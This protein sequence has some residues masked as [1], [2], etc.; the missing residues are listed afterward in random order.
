[1]S[2]P[3]FTKRHRKS[4]S[5]L[6]RWAVSYL[7]ILLI[8]NLIFMYS[9]RV[10]VS[11]MQN[12]IHSANEL[13]LS[14][15]QSNIDKLLSSA[16]EAYAYVYST[17]QFS[18]VKLYTQ[19]ND[20]F[21]YDVTKLIKSLGA[22][23]S[24]NNN[25]IAMLIYMKDFNYI[26]S[27][28]TANSSLAL[29]GSQKI[30]GM[31]DSYDDWLSALQSNYSNSFFLSS[32]LQIGN[33]EPCIIYANTLNLSTENINIFISIPLSRAEEYTRSLT[34]RTL[35]IND[36]D[37]NCI[38]SFGSD[39][40]PNYLDLSIPSGNRVAD[41]NGDY[42]I[43][44]YSKSTQTDWY[45]SIITPETSFFKTSQSLNLLFIGS[46]V[47]SLLLGATLV[48]LLL[49]RNYKPVG[50]IL[51][52]IDPSDSAGDE[53]DLIKSSYKQLANE[54]RTMQST[55][56]KQAEQLKERYILSRLKG[57]KSHLNNIDAN[58]YYQIDIQ[59]K[60]F[61]LVAFSVGPLSA[62][63]SANY[64]DEL[65][66]YDINLFAID[67]A[68]TEIMS[69]YSFYKMED[70]Q[71]LLYLLHLD[72]AQIKLWNSHAQLLITEICDLFLQKLSVPL[73]AVISETIENFNHISFLYSDVMA[74]MEYKSII[75]E[76]GVIN[77]ADL[78]DT[79]MLMDKN[80]MRTQCLSDAV[81]EGNFDKAKEMITNVFEE[82]KMNMALPFSVF[83]IVVTNYL[84]TILNSFY[85]SAPDISQHNKLLISKLEP[86]IASSETDTLYQNTCEFL[87][88]ICG[89]IAN[90]NEGK[91]NK[92]V[93]KMKDY[94]L[95]SYQDSNLNISAIAEAMERSP[96]YV[97]H[98]FKYQTGEGLLDHINKVRI[99][100]AKEIMEQREITME[101]LASRVGYTNDR[102]FRRA[103]TRAEGT[104]PSKYRQNF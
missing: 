78:K 89:I 11:T 48:W 43:C 73:T 21:R 37:G 25:S 87:A 66:Y 80:A 57:K 104:C 94:I 17:Q 16:R 31:T 49:R 13:V 69:S 83:R 88:F 62:D 9:Y 3:F 86:L 4:K 33:S 22:Y 51:S 34:D 7:L 70:G 63:D 82:Y 103:F 15:L 38:A 26:I 8:P 6:S 46:F 19:N 35:M 24:N 74:A 91:E 99:N 71:L 81:G 28:G 60:A 45:Y 32:D 68:F 85:E 72:K 97:S 39:S 5:I 100:K 96:R 52:I 36:R 84:N 41:T 1:L 53:F 90:Q 2:N 101:E 77:T 76:S 44:A 18:K 64:Q 67:N 61:V 55:L 58:T 29:Y 65:E 59:D 47:V 50:S 92:L 42:Y 54:N 23:A 95:H 56:T 27:N 30:C 79:D 75:G 98:I 93:E 40:S 10:S 12:E 14:N 102:T 20:F